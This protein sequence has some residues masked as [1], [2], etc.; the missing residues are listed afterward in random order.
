MGE[1]KIMVNAKGEIK[2]KEH[3]DATKNSCKK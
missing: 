3:I 1:I 2:I